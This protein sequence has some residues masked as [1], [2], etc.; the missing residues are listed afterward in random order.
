MKREG[1]MKKGVL[2]VL[3]FSLGIAF[4]GLLGPEEGCAGEVKFIKIATGNP[5]GRWYPFGAKLSELIT[6]YLK[7]VN[8][9]VTAGGGVSNCKAVDKNEVQLGVTYGTSS[10][11][12]F[13]GKPP[14]EKKLHNIRGLGVIEMSYYNAVVRKD[15]D[16]K[17]FADLK[18]KK[19]A[20]GPPGFFSAVTT[21]NILKAYGLSFDEV[22]K[23]GGTIS[24]VSW[25]DAGEMMKDRNVDFIGVLTGIP[26]HT[27]LS[28]TT[29]T[30]IR[31]LDIDEK[32][33]KTILENEPGYLI[34]L[35]PA[36]TYPGVKTD[37][38][39]LATDTQFVC[40][41]D[42]PDDLVYKI[43]KLFYEEVPKFKEAF[44]QFG[45]VNVKRGYADIKLPMH[46]GAKR[47]F[48]EKLK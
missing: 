35:I 15:S 32:Y 45:E 14:F 4:F 31:L 29:A 24:N 8:A 17:S 3:V 39:T 9:S 22:R 47:Y 13:N 36:N 30:S 21:E 20:P 33:Q 25:S 41:K 1:T 23:S 5:A 42:L 12:A 26:H 38:V 28:L 11:N 7:P 40:H 6:Q 34:K 18:D 19:I 10:Y 44:K 2:L 43:T 48:D 37:T 27:I 46:P 16:I